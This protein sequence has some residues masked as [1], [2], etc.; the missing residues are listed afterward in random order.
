M[1]ETNAKKEGLHFTGIY[2]WDKEEVKNRI[3]DEKEKYPKA[4]IR[5]VNSPPSRLSR[6]HH[7]MGY[8][9]YADEIY[10]AYQTIEQYEPRIKNHASH[11]AEIKKRHAEELAKEEKTYTEIIERFNE[12]K[13]KL[14]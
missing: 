11:I 9:A 12:A 2:S 3:K 1:T 10:S 13:E 5:L 6:G 8:S 7:G 14:A 4:R